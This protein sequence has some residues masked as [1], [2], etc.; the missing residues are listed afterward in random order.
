MQPDTIVGEPHEAG[1]GYMVEIGYMVSPFFQNAVG[2]GGCFVA[3]GTGAN[4]K[5][6]RR[7]SVDKVNSALRVEVDF[8]AFFSRRI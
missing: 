7:F 6:Q 8:D 3:F 4:R 5:L 1:H 2:A